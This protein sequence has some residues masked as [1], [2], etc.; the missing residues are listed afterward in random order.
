MKSQAHPDRRH[1]K[2]QLYKLKAESR[3]HR[4]RV[5]ST[6]Y[7]P[8]ITDDY[9]LKFGKHIGNTAGSL[10]DDYLRWLLESWQFTTI[11]PDSFKD[12]FITYINSRLNPK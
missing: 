1:D 5:H 8:V 6:K 11:Y 4:F 3:E 12:Q 10:P 9:I 2:A 7:H